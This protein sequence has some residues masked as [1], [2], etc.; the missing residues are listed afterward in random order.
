MTTRI[1]R[2]EVI[3][4][5]VYINRADLVKMIKERGLHYLSSTALTLCIEIA[6]ALEAG[7]PLIG[8]EETNEI[9]SEILRSRTGSSTGN[10]M[11]TG[12][13]S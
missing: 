4:G 13:L 11:G 3:K 5:E 10:K 1:L 9:Q 6:E 2:A 8:E 12:W 7:T